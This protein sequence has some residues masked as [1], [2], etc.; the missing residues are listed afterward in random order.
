MT[1]T[2]FQGRKVWQKYKLEIVLLDSCL[3]LLKCCMVA[4]YTR[5]IMYS[6]NC[7]MLMRVQRR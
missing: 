4:T 6:M 1:L 2:F 3:L 7:S 5:K